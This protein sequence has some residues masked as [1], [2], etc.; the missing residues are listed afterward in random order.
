MKMKMKSTR[1]VTLVI[2]TLAVGLSACQ[3]RGFNSGSL[4]G[5]GSDAGL[6]SDRPS[7]P[8]KDPKK[9]FFFGLVK[10]K[11]PALFET[12][13]ILNGKIEI[14][15]DQ[16]KAIQAEQDKFISEFKNLSPE[17]KAFYQYKYILNAVAI[18]VPGEVV[19]RIMAMDGVQSVVEATSFRRPQV[20][21]V[22]AG[23]NLN[24]IERNSVKFIGAEAARTMRW[25]LPNG[26]EVTG[27]DGA[28]MSVGVIDTGI[29]FTHKMFGGEGTEAA[30]KAIDPSKPTAAFPNAKVVGGYDFVGTKY[31]SRN[32]DTKLP[33]PDVNPLDEADHGTH[34]AGTVAGIGDG[35]N[36]Y[37]GVAPG[38]TLHALKVFGKDGSTD[39][40][41]VIA[42]LEYAA[43]PNNDGDL[44]DQ[45]D[46]VNLSLGSPYGSANALYNQAISN[47]VRGG[48]VVVASAG[49]SGDNKFI[50]GEPA[51]SDEAIS[52]AASVDNMD[53][54]WQFDTV[55][56]QFAQGED[57]VVE[58]IES[59][60]T[61]PIAEIGDVQGK[62]VFL[63]LADVDLTDEQKASLKGH[64]ALID[65]GKVTFADKIKRAA[66]GGAIGVVVVNSVP[67]EPMAMGGDGGPYEIP[68]IMI[69][70]D[71]GEKIKEQMKTGEVRI[72]FKNADKIQRPE[73]IDTI[74]GF[75]SR[76]P[77]SADGG[78]KPEISSPG[79]SIVS[80]KAGAGDQGLKMSGTSMAGPHIAGVMALLKQAH[81]NL[82]PVQLKS[83]LLGQAKTIGDK[84]QKTYPVARQGSGRVQVVESITSPLVGLPST[85]SL[86]IVPIQTVKSMK[87]S[88]ELQNITANDLTVDLEFEGISHPIAMNPIKGVAIKAGTTANVDLRFVITTAGMTETIREFDGW[89]KV[90][91]AGKEVLRVPV[92]ALAQKVTNIEAT[93]LQVLAAGLADAPESSTNLKLKNKGVQDG[94]A[95]VFNLLGVDARKL[96]K[97]L[98]PFTSRLCDLQAAG[99]RLL[100]KNIEGKTRTVIQVAAK[101]YEPMTTWHQ[102]DFSVLLDINGDQLL[103]QELAIISRSSLPGIAAPGRDEEMVGLLLDSNK[104][105]AIRDAHD[106]LP[107]P[108]PGEKKKDIDFKE[109]VIAQVPVTLF[110]HSTITMVEIDVTALA[111]RETGELAIRIATTHKDSSPIEVDDFLGTLDDW[112]RV[113]ILEK[114]QAY[115]GMPESVTV[116]AGAEV[117][118]EF[119][120]GYGRGEM[121]VLF[122]D[123]SF[124]VSDQLFD[125]QATVVQP[126]FA[127]ESYKKD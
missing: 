127:Y 87:R 26:S 58:A 45:L 25:K 63:G 111:R 99:Y 123:N 46:V 30:Y 102:C 105:R 76:G 98:D 11:T 40:P 82:T 97:N 16:L 108:P 126:V 2:A 81:P 115:Y 86:G 32:P 94:R 55:R 100:K 69:T 90:K 17:V 114:S 61:K 22:S 93:E 104:G 78:I 10:L 8:S 110:D 13:K 3:P 44:A 120:K 33:E 118:L 83:L 70:K 67:G 52:V 116:P 28:G 47:L 21:R 5:N 88:L 60:L 84:E 24:I 117:T 66:E 29:D 27:I 85:L 9:N 75:S 18:Y 125:D 103:D 89:V 15:Q 12:G 54:N 113:S 41:I 124:V 7:A 107:T 106:S 35:V 39:D 38:A 20:D 95:M 122:P 109:A 119:N 19:I 34:V 96:N 51:A 36:T 53:H 14:D 68:G 65:R 121:L 72:Q 31:D 50:T 23:T 57:S 101:L 73:L 80:A 64:V 48:T 112:M 42:A 4:T 92:L 71:L 43:D 1:S 62:F 74:T 91:S 59:T 37:S 49:N 6:F 56:I 79:Q 77:R